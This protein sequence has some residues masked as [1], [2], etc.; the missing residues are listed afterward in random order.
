MVRVWPKFVL[1]LIVLTALV[2]APAGP[3][4]AQGREDLRRLAVEGDWSILERPNGACLAVPTEKAAAPL[5]LVFAA[6]PAAVIYTPYDAGIGG[7]VILKVDRSDPL[8]VMAASIPD[9]NRIDVPADLIP[10]MW[11]GR[12]LILEIAPLD[13]DPEI[14]E[15][16]L[17][18]LS[19]AVSWL[20]K[21]RCRVR[22]QESEQ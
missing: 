2:V 1:R 3:S 5:S 17:S 22:T 15:F 16:S 7:F 11:A 19:A 18:G 14:H 8:Y 9:P 10:E 20:D 12:R 4:A 6:G 13:R 21:P